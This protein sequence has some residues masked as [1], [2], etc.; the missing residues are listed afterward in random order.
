M[1]RNIRRLSLTTSLR[2]PEVDAPS[3]CLVAALLDG[4][5]ERD[6][7][8][9]DEQPYKIVRFVGSYL[10][11]EGEVVGGISVQHPLQT[12]RRHRSLTKMG[13]LLSAAI[14]VQAWL[15]NS[16][17]HH[18][19]PNLEDPLS[20]F[21]ENILLECVRTTLHAA[22]SRTGSVFGLPRAANFQFR[23]VQQ[24]DSAK[25]VKLLRLRMMD[26]L[27]VTEESSVLYGCSRA[28]ALKSAA[29]L[30]PSDP[31]CIAAAEGKVDLMFAPFNSLTLQISKLI[32]KAPAE[33]SDRGHSLESF[34][35]ALQ[36]LRQPGQTDRW[37]ELCGDSRT[38]NSW[39]GDSGDEDSDSGSDS[40][41]DDL[42]RTQVRKLHWRAYAFNPT[43]WPTSVLEHFPLFTAHSLAEA[44][45]RAGHQLPCRGRLEKSR[46]EG[47]LWRVK[48]TWRRHGDVA[49]SPVYPWLSVGTTAEWNPL[50]II[51]QRAALID[52][53]RM[54]S[55]RKSSSNVEF[56]LALF[57]ALLPA[58]SDS[59]L[60][61]VPSVKEWWRRAMDLGNFN[62]TSVD[63]FAGNMDSFVVTILLSVQ[64]LLSLLRVDGGFLGLRDANEHQRFLQKLVPRLL[65]AC[66]LSPL[67]ALAGERVISSFENIAVTTQQTSGKKACAETVS[68]KFKQWTDGLNEK[69]RRASGSL[70][71]TPVGRPED[72]LLVEALDR[73]LKCLLRLCR[74]KHFCAWFDSHGV[75][76]SLRM[77]EMKSDVLGCRAVWSELF[78][79]QPDAISALRTS[80][81]DGVL[82]SLVPL[83]AVPP[84]QPFDANRFF[85]WL[86]DEENMQ[87]DVEPSVT[88]TLRVDGNETL[89]VPPVTEGRTEE[90]EGLQSLRIPPAAAEAESWE[91]ARWTPLSG[92]QPMQAQHK[93]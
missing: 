56:V 60:S 52:C 28:I 71:Q 23:T 17:L 45:S 10:F 31:R 87:S 4:E 51:H 35:S 77:H 67:F 79:P 37:L 26:S 72:Y 40:D 21:S 75:C 82:P 61:V 76:L 6:S 18:A 81:F 11:G 3:L 66:L 49:C 27:D 74:S 33:G 14:L 83:I 50:L 44:S 59:V 7:L 73:I 15:G 84:S 41:E 36:A 2:L 55:H 12:G 1:N 9:E 53:L 78:P 57:R 46:T 8:D 90:A 5:Q 54:H 70:G 85:D 86:L 69:M 13:A 65:E 30:P 16:A 68:S 92:Q 80:L 38:F 25:I 29:T 91:D 93:N 47:L 42:D 20:L 22:Y 19:G 43:T 24:L 63:H 89:P 62:P 32:W 34:S 48:A 88:D 64:V 39:M 58:P